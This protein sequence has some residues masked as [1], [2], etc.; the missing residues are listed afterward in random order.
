MPSHLLPASHLERQAFVLIVEGLEIHEVHVR[1]DR[2]IDQILFVHIDI[3]VSDSPPDLLGV[4][5]AD[6]SP[7]VG[8]LRIEQDDVRLT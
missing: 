1:R 5:L 6:L 4:D 2:A 7:V 3:H 8:V